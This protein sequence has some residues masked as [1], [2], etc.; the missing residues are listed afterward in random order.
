VLSTSSARGNVFRVPVRDAGGPRPMTD[1]CRLCGKP[2]PLQRS[3]IIPEFLYRPLYD[4]KHRIS[5]VKVGSDRIG[6]LQKG[7]TEALLC[8]GC[9]QKL[10]LYEK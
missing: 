4:E 8:F 10:A 5:V 2:S 3:H 7:F 6:Y 1:I 9:E